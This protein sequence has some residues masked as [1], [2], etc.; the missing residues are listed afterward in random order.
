M[1]ID[2]NNSPA[3]GKLVFR[4][5]DYVEFDQSGRALCPCCSPNHKSKGKTLSLVPNTDGAYKCFRGC[6][7]QEIR[8][9]LGVPKKQYQPDNFRSHTP[10]AFLPPKT[11]TAQKKQPK[12]YPEKKILDEHLEL[13][14][15]KGSALDAIRYLANRHITTDLIKHYKL[16][17]ARTNCNNNMLYSICVPIP[18]ED[19]YMIKKRVAPWD[20][21]A[22]EIDG[23][24]AWSQYGVSPTVYFSYKP[25]NTSSTWLC[26]GEWDAMLLGW[27][28]RQ[29]QADFAV[30]TLTCGAGK[31]KLPPKSELD[32][33]IGDVIIFYDRNDKL[34]NG[35]RAGEVTA[36]DLAK[37]L[38][39]RG[40]IASVPMPENCTVKGW[41][42][43][44][45][46]K[47]GYT[48]E[49]FERAALEARSYQ[50]LEHNSFA[51]RTRTLKKLYDESDDYIEWVVPDI[52]PPN[53]AVLL[54]ASPRV[55]KSL[56]A[57]ALA[58]AIAGG[59][60]FLDRPCPKGKVLY[61]C[62]EDSD[63]KVKIRLNM[64]GWTDEELNNVIVENDFTM[65]EF[66]DLAEYVKEVRP[67]LII[68]D[69]L[70]RIHTSNIGEN[71][72]EMKNIIAPIQDLARKENVCCLIIHHTVKCIEENADKVNIFDLARGS[73]QI[74][75]TCRASMI[76][77]KTKE[78]FRLVVEN[79][80]GSNLDLALHLNPVDLIWRLNGNWL[81][82]DVDRSQKDVVFDWFKKH[83]EGTIEQVYKGTN[84]PKRNIYQIL[85]RLINQGAIARSG[86]QRTTL[87]YLPVQQVQQVEDLLKSQNIYIDSNR[88]RSST[89]CQ[90]DSPI[91]KPIAKDTKL[92]VP[93]HK[94]ADREKNTIS[95]EL[96][97]QYAQ[98]PID[99]NTSDVQQSSTN[100]AVVELNPQKPI[101]SDRVSFDRNAHTTNFFED[102]R[103]YSGEEEKTEE[104]QSLSGVWHKRDGYMIVI[105]QRKSKIEVRRSGER[106]SRWIFLKSCD[107][108]REY[109]TYCTF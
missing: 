12:L 8:E 27:I 22:K 103:S 85:T 19:G 106:K 44:D 46:I 100:G 69:T 29:N 72:S 2:Y 53:E 37:E 79:G 58:R 35:V 84:L 90:K 98:M 87:Y 3:N 41:D 18:Y 66:P 82:P 59:R 38:G 63:V 15:L 95:V 74:R 51:Q 42:V 97:G 56:F 7:T 39:D 6:T 76:L 20:K 32:K 104:S 9:S 31:N 108:R 33:L 4:I 65:D 57:L 67:S 45:A 17:L 101:V 80:F 36:K 11:K 77:A 94:N 13:M 70:S 28:A 5:T 49:S 40:K 24:K 109:E 107:N 93:D 86:S 48:L 105:S 50:K 54:S 75:N 21:K 14:S 96:S 60:K 43:T 23:Y 71:S 16:G 102:L 34:V 99:I 26:E 52:L 92:Y 83:K 1:N 47:E 64:Q 78:G 25:K 62:K 30:A 10:P 81:P 89:T 55:G 73:G 88:H 61:I 68:F 91:E